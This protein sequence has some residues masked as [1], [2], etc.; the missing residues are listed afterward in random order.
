[1]QTLLALMLSVSMAEAAVTGVVKDPT[2]AVVQGATVILRSPSGAEQQ[3]QTDSDGRFVFDRDPEGRATVIVKAG[4]FDEAQQSLTAAQNVEIVLAQQKRGETIVVTPTRGVERLGNLPVSLDVIDGQQI[5]RSPAM[6]ADD[7]LRRVPTFSLFRRASSL[8]QHPTSQGVSLRNIGPT[9]A[10]R[11]L[12]LIDN[13][14]FNDP[15]GGWVY[16]T[17]VPLDDISRI[18]VVNSSSSSLYGNY[19]MGGVINIVSNRPQRRTI[20]LKPQFGNLDTR[21]LDFF[22]SDVWG[23]LGIAVS[24]T[25]FDTGGFQNVKPA[26]RGIIDSNN[27]VQFSN[28]NIKANYDISNN[29]KAFFRGGYFHEERDN[30]KVATANGTPVGE[31]NGTPEQNETKWKSAAGGVKVVLPDQSDL[32]VTV[33]SDFEDF[34]SNFLAVPNPQTRLTARVS[35]NQHVPSIRNIGGMAQWSRGFMGKHYVSVGSD[36]RF[37]KGD[38]EE[39]SMDTTFGTTVTLERMAGG[40]QRNLGVFV[41]DVFSP[42][43]KLTITASARVDNWRNYDAHNLETSRP[44]GAP[45]A[46]HNPDLP[47]REDTVTSPRV[48]ALYRLTDRVNVWGDISWGFRAPTLNELYRQFRQGPRLVLGNFDL[49]P[50]RLTGGE[51]GVSLEV[52]PDLLVRGTLFD[53]RVKDPV[54]S[55]T[56]SV[57][58]ALTTQQRQNLARTRIWGIQTDAEYKFGESFLFSAGYLY[59][60]AK[61]KEAANEQQAS[62]VGLFLA[63]VPEHRGSFQATYL[64]PKLVD[65][66]L[67]VQFV[68]RQFDDDLNILAI[69]GATEPGLPKFG[70]VD[71]TASRA[72]TSNVEVFFGVQNLLDKEYYVATGPTLIGTPRLVNGGLRVRWADR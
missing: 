12:V 27:T 63:Q 65:L 47:D 61:V 7:V 46:G 28:V 51:G 33:F 24:G 2:G 21:K 18:E 23:K 1:M 17:R 49:A 60:Q 50:E 20:E 5:R 52:T 67:G 39:N 13:I 43:P 41:Q 71:F 6:V 37:V 30:G 36:W 45:G 48:G 57:T 22:A 25:S 38:S 53:N 26:E 70:L 11:T 55:V 14:P 10:G 69:T 15:F 56:T 32:Q 44:S 3:T 8:A 42:T 64:N 59:N 9:G 31:P 16:W 54:A 62:L 72:V 58:P 68:G 19:A 34:R 4:G 66:S 40:K 29:V 35:V